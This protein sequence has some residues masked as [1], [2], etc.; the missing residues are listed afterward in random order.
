MKN[1]LIKMVL[2]AVFDKLIESLKRLVQRSSSDI[3]NK[4]VDVIVSNRAEII[5][6]IKTRL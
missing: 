5:R 1:Y 2:D 3:D 4:I 6:D